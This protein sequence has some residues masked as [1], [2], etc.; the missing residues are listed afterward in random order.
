[1]FFLYSLRLISSVVMYVL[2]YVLKYVHTIDIFMKI[3][4]DFQITF[5]ER[6]NEI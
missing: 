3:K 4:V 6:I 2:C 1:M 5:F